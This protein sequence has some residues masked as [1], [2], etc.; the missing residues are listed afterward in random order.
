MPTFNYT[1]TNYP[2][3]AFSKIRSADTNQMFSDITTFLNTTK[4]TSTNVQVHGLVRIGATSNLAV[5]TAKAMFYNDSNGD[6]AELSSVNN[7][8]VYFNASGNPTA[9]AGLPLASGGTGASLTN[10]AVP[11]D[12]LQVNAA[13]TAI[14]LSAP[15]GVSASLRLF[16]YYNL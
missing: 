14:E 8:A 6:M 10:T 2:F 7:G 15:S 3:Q 4:L 9:T 5:G 11:G 16:Q 12:V 13:G 1:S